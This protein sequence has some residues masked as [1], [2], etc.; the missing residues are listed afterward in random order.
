MNGTQKWG[1]GG[2]VVGT[3]QFPPVLFSFSRF[4]NPRGLDYLGARTRLH[5]RFFVCL[6]FSH[7]VWWWFLQFEF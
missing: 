5:H 3:G 4:L 2:G 7:S 6:F 1:G